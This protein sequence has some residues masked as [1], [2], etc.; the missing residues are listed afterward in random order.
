M[1]RFKWVKLV[2]W[3]MYAPWM[4]LFCYF[5]LMC[6]SC[7][8]SKYRHRVPAPMDCTVR[9]AHPV[10]LYRYSPAEYGIED[11]HPFYLGFTSMLRR[12][13]PSSS[14]FNFQRAE[15]WGAVWLLSTMPGQVLCLL[16]VLLSFS[17][18]MVL[19][20]SV[21]KC[22]V[23]TSHFLSSAFLSFFQVELKIYVSVVLL[24]QVRLQL[25]YSCS[26]RCYTPQNITTRSTARKFG[27]GMVSKLWLNLVFVFLRSV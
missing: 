15:N 8:C 21:L 13:S 1:V 20:I 10:R 25:L 5:G 9:D 19:F 18:L 22:V 24:Q 14:R 4:Y 12:W 11:S 27:M 7:S 17:C 23:F 16:L 2:Y 3:R 26:K 6:S